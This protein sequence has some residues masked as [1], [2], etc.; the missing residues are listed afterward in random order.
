MDVFHPEIN[1]QLVRI[2]HDYKIIQGTL[3]DFHY[4]TNCGGNFQKIFHQI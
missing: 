1:N 2:L 3:K 4:R